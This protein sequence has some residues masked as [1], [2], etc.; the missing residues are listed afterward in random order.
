MELPLM[1]VCKKKITKKHYF[2]HDVT[3]SISARKFTTPYGSTA[4]NLNKK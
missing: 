3:Y 1:E 2:N 4:S